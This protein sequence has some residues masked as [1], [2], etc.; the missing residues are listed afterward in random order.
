[1]EAID[2]PSDLEQVFRDTADDL[3]KYFARRHPDREQAQDLVQDTF[4]E[5]ARGL[6][7]GRSPQSYRAYLFGIARRLSIAAWK[8]RDR[9]AVVATGQPLEET[10]AEAAPDERIDAAREIIASLP[11]LQREI[12][13]LRFTQGLSYAEIAEALNIP[14][15]TVRSR[16]HHAVGA[17]RRAM[18]A[19]EGDNTE[20]NPSPPSS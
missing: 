12:L 7:K 16:L 5:M 9:E 13:D 8:R 20:P 3:A 10:T 6:R 4:M 1:M 14:L 19:E 17:I 2:Q 18:I 11:P 15:G